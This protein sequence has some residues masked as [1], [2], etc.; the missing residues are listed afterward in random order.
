MNY[1]S[2]IYR[3]FSAA[4]EAIINS[5]QFSSLEIQEKMISIQDF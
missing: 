2:A 1:D 3:C 4:L 5:E